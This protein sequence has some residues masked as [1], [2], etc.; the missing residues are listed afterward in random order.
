MRISAVI[1]EGR[2]ERHPIGRTRHSSHYRVSGPVLHA[3]VPSL[4]VTRLFLRIAP[5]AIGLQLVA[6]TA[7]TGVA[8]ASDG[9]AAM[10]GAYVVH[11]STTAAATDAARAV[12]ATPT[13][14]YDSAFAGFA[15]RLTPTQ[16]Q[17]IESRP[18]VLGVE[19]DRRVTPIEPAPP[20]PLTEAT[21]LDP[22]NWG[23]DRIDQRN[24]PLDGRY[25]TK[26]T[27][28]GVTVWVLDTGVDTT[29]PEFGGRATQVDNTV[30]ST[31]GDCDGH[32]TVV[33]GIAASS[34]HGVAK[35]ATVRSV[36]VLDC[37][38]SGTLSTLLAGIDFVAK[39]AHGPSVAVMSWSYGPS[40]VL[41]A[42][43]SKLVA[44][45]VFVASSA[46]NTG[47]DDCTVAPRAAVG[48]L[49][50]A[51]STID[52]KRNP[53]SSTGSCVGLYAPG[54]GIVAPVPGGGTA[55]YTGT[56]M[57]APFV[58]GVAALYKQTFGDKPSATVKQWIEDHAVPNVIDG[59]GTG[60]TPNLLLD[61][62]GL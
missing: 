53:T 5:V 36:K 27:G 22:P 54:T 59:G 34:L 18:G 4:H 13:V 40:D 20:A 49:V 17:G 35:Q 29:H 33:A 28:S 21:E 47:A 9:S 7:G 58:A 52:D 25:T 56:S 42:A 3:C 2:T 57:A 48:V 60:G 43:V 46:G 15:A 10:V 62:G 14:T 37:N 39:N 12:G 26:A 45:G 51:N 44:Q 6:L 31:A 11:A 55:S 41:V 30:D 24:L 23:L 50:V 1:E 8:S 32:G 19:Q 38:G 61:T 16:V